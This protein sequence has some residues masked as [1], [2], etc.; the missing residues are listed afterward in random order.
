[1]TYTIEFQYQHHVCGSSSHQAIL[2]ILAIISE[3]FIKL[4]LQLLHQSTVFDFSV[5]ID[6]HASTTIETANCKPQGQQLIA[7]RRIVVEK[8]DVGIANAA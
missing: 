4:I 8:L 3:S 2:N 1:M 7:K 6:R 5:C